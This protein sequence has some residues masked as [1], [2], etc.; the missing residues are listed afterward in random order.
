V[1]AHAVLRRILARGYARVRSQVRVGNDNH[2]Y[3]IDLVVDGPE[4]RIAVECDGE[5]WHGEE[6]WH[7]DRARQ[8][9]LERAD[10]LRY[11]RAELWEPSSGK[12]HP[13]PGRATS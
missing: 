12:I 5:R 2:H 13:R 1:S 6:R 9:V 3:R 7:A 8:E 10:I 11:R 4:S